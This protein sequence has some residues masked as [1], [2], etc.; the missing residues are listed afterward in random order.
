M[1]LVDVD[2]GS[3]DRSSP[4]PNH[5]DR[6]ND[7]SIKAHK[8]IS[9]HYATDADTNTGRLQMG[10]KQIITNNGTYTNSITGQQSDGKFATEYLDSNG[11][12]VARFG[13]QA[14]G[15]INAKFFDTSAVGVA[16]FGRF[17]DG[18]T[19][20]KV[21]KSGI[22]VSTATNDQLI[23]NSSQDVFKIVAAGTISVSKGTNTVYASS[24]I[25]HWSYLHPIS[26]GFRVN[27]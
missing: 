6:L 12:V 1:S 4:Q 21:A 2:M 22:E 9:T 16:Q 17:A 3:L 8:T 24:S 19:A 5:S 7:G 25:N 18:S 23:F 20:L 13:E 11:N 10:N 27:S 26:Y 15:T 14:D